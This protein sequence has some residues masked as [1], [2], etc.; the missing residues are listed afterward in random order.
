VSAGT[1]ED[2]QSDGA[3]A[4]ALA[5]FRQMLVHGVDVDVRHDQGSAGATGRTDGA[6][7]VRPGEPPV[8]LD[9]QARALLGPDA[10]QRALLADAVD[11]LRRSN[12]LEPDFDLSP[13]SRGGIVARANSAT[14]F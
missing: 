8:A 13:A 11:R 5:D 12:I 1:V 14:F 7:Q 2:Q 10:G 3:Q 9:P 6:K 4:D